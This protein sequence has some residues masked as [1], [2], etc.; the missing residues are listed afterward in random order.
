MSP[1]SGFK[2]SQSTFLLEGSTTFVCFFR[3]KMS[4]KFSLF[5]SNI[6][7][8]F[9]QYLCQL[10]TQ[11]DL[12]LADAY[13]NGDISFVDESEGLLNLLI[14]SK[15]QP[16]KHKEKENQ[17]PICSFHQDCFLNNLLQI[18]VTNRDRKLSISRSSYI[19]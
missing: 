8:K 10:A 3:F 16:H 1:Q 5:F 13:I 17:S 7:P 2:S 9:K 18:F 11:E 15:V 19:Q 4:V 6:K 14:V 12:G